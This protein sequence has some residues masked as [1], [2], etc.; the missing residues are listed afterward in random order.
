MRFRP[1]AFAE[2]HVVDFDLDAAAGTAALRYRLGDDLEFEEHLE[3]GT[4]VVPLSPGQEAGLLAVI[5]LLHVVAGV[6]YY[7]A[8]APQTISVHTGALSGVEHE[9]VAAVYDHG[10]REFRFRNGLLERAPVEVVAA[11]AVVQH[12]RHDIEPPGRGGVVPR[13]GG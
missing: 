7:K 3:L 1:E 4:P 9:L 10:L 5:R 6:S 2:F 13:G 12:D 11:G 8:A